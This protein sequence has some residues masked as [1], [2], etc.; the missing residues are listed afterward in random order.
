MSFEE[1]MV[2]VPFKHACDK[3]LEIIGYEDTQVIFANQNG[4]EPDNTY[5]VIQVLGVTQVG[6][7][8]EAS[9]LTEDEILETITNY[10]LDVQLSFIGTTSSASAQA[11]RHG[12][13]ND[14]RCFE[15]L[16]RSNFGIIDR[17]QIRKIPQKRESDWVDAYNMDFSFSFAILTRFSYD[18]IEYVDFEGVIIHR[19]PKP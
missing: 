3:I 11:F 17:G 14:R 1:R 12:M 19:T 18:W 9:T 13:V 8:T 10:K 6:R 7:V 5:C 15:T 2:T 16:M 4:L